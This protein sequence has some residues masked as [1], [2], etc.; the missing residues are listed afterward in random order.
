[1]ARSY[2]NP[3]QQIKLSAA[4][5]ATQDNTA[6]I[7]QRGASDLG[8][9]VE[10][11]INNSEKKSQDD[12]NKEALKANV[13][14]RYG[15]KKANTS[16]EVTVNDDGT[17]NLTKTGQGIIDKGFE[18]E[19]RLQSQASKIV[20]E[21]A[22]EYTA[23]KLTP[24]ARAKV[25]SDIDAAL[26]TPDQK[27]NAKNLVDQRQAEFS[28]IPNSADAKAA[29][30]G[31]L[32]NL[33]KERLERS[34][35][36][37]DNIARQAITFD[38]DSAAIRAKAIGGA[39]AETQLKIGVINR[40][41]RRE[42]IQD[43]RYKAGV[44]LAA[45]NREEDKA[46]T[47]LQQEIDN[48]YRD[49]KFEMALQKQDELFRHNAKIEGY[50]AEESQRKRT[51]FN[52][53]QSDRQAAIKAEGVQASTVSGVGGLE[54]VMKTVPATEEAILKART[55]VDSKTRETIGD[56]EIVKLANKLSPK[57][58]ALNARIKENSLK[59]D[60]NYLSNKRDEAVKVLEKD[61]TSGKIATRQEYRE[62]LNALI[63]SKEYNTTENEGI[64][65]MFNRVTGTTSAATRRANT[66]LIAD[67]LEVASLQKQLN[68]GATKYSNDFS[69]AYESNLEKANAL[70]QE[71]ATGDKRETL[72]STADFSDALL[73]DLLAQQGIDPTDRTRG[74]NV[75][76]T[77]NSD[78]YKSKVAEHKVRIKAVAA[79]KADIRKA[80]VEWNTFKQKEEFKA[81]T[82]AGKADKEQEN[83]I[84]L[85]QRKEKLAEELAK[86]KE[87]I[88]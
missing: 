76:A 77:R 4:P 58:D 17:L 1:M 73:K 74:V 54:D 44:E 45:A 6:A 25:F 21:K 36:L 8:A 26:M 3:Y 2:G 60:P 33:D 5:T 70:T 85:A 80:Q 68:E 46:T 27:I 75:K 28:R 10:R 50:A 15:A 66:Q 18:V 41:N 24:E 23:N 30:Y 34:A 83:K 47:A 65:G 16:G 57:I 43:E 32:S 56:K 12:A 51:L 59:A 86:Y 69:Q 61:Y 29:A 78:I 79:I 87:S 52:Q 39:D 49:G 55:A 40:Q 20:E 22:G 84:E 63:T 71:V 9:I 48:A 37:Q 31:S 7:I 53:K 13:D 38:Q 81:L 11:G 62:K 88:S 14:E 72:L 42:A 64:G 67:K 82:A 35:R 19:K